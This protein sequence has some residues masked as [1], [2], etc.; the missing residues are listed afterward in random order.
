M[1]HNMRTQLA[2]ILT[3]SISPGQLDR[4]SAGQLRILVPQGPLS[5]YD[6]LV[7]VA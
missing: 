7:T 2:I 3:G 4:A 6:T 5:Q 1:P